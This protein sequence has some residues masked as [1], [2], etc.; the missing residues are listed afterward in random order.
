LF[1]KGIDRHIERLPGAGMRVLVA[2]GLL[3]RN[4]RISLEGRLQAGNHAGWAGSEAK[5]NKNFWTG[6]DHS[7]ERVPGAG[8]G[9][10]WHGTMQ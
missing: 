1:Q 7:L 2:D 10:P 9:H 8:R 4:C 3:R 5:F 6:G